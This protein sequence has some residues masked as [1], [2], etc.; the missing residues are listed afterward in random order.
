MGPSFSSIEVGE[1]PSI[2]GE[3]EPSVYLSVIKSLAT[4]VSAIHS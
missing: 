3:E 1:M 4:P 2:E